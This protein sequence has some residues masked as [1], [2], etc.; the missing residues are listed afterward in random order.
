MRLLD[1]ETTVLKKVI[2]EKNITQ[3]ELSRMVAI[4]YPQLNTYCN[5]SNVP[6]QKIKQR[7]AD[8]LQVPVEEI[9]P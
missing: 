2:Y 9:F 6:G 4:A 5:G 1:A 7:I 3:A 8:V